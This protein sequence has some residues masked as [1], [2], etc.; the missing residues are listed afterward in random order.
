MQQRTHTLLKLE[1]KW[2]KAKG[3]F[4][5]HQVVIKKWL[6]KNSIGDKRFQVCDLVLKWDK[7]H[8][9]KGK[10]SKF[11]SLWLGPFV[12]YW[13]LGPTNFI[14]K[15]EGEFERIHINGQSLKIYFS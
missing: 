3:K 4:Q 2:E 5:A 9:A 10:H 8:E 1:E 12:V 15:N 7:A 11:Q 6:D 14:L 13:Q